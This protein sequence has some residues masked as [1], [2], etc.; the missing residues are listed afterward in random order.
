MGQ[1]LRDNQAAS[2]V[3]TEYEET[4]KKSGID[5]K[6]STDRVHTGQMILKLLQQYTKR[7]ITGLEPSE[8]KLGVDDLIEDYYLPLEESCKDQEQSEHLG[9]DQTGPCSSV[10]IFSADRCIEQQSDQVTLALQDKYLLLQIINQNLGCYVQE[11]A[12]RSLAAAHGLIED[13]FSNFTRRNI[14]FGDYPKLTYDEINQLLCNHDYVGYCKYLSTINDN[15]MENNHV[16]P[17]VF[18]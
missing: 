14:G 8:D 9:C 2:D 16:V 6:H 13:L 17:H 15:Q 4:T 1:S 12:G 18:R 7:T 5:D 3:V 10:S 11:V